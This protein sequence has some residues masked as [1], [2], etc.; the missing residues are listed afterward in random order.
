MA[1]ALIIYASQDK[2]Y[3]EA[4]IQ[5]ARIRQPEIEFNGLDNVGAFALDAS[6]IRRYDAVIALLSPEALA[7]PAISHVLAACAQNSDQE[8]VVVIIRPVDVPPYLA[9]TPRV[10]AE[11]LSPQQFAD[12]IFAPIDGVAT[13]EEIVA[14]EALKEAERLRGSGYFDDQTPIEDKPVG[15]YA[16]PPA[17]DTEAPAKE[18]PSSHWPTIEEERTLPTDV[19]PVLPPAPAQD[20]PA[21]PEPPA[22]QPSAPPYAPPPPAP[23]A[24]PSG[25]VGETVG[26]PIFTLPWD[27][28]G[29]KTQVT[30]TLQFSAYHPNEAPVEEWQT[31]L[32][33]TH[34]TEHLGQ[35]QADAGTFT[36]LGSAP[37]VAQGQALRKIPRNIEITVEPHMEGVTFSP[38][39]D[40]FIW[41]GEWHRSLFRYSGAKEL[42]GT[43]QKGWI[44]IYADHISPICT[45][46]VSFSFRSGIPTTALSVPHG[47]TVTS[48][49]FDTVFISYSHRDRE[50][51]RQARETYEKLGITAYHDDFLEAGDN[52]E[53]QLEGMIRT[54]RVFHLLWSDASAQSAE[55]RK[56]WAL[57]LEC[58][59]GEK[60]IRPWYWQ[61]QL[62]R[63]PEELRARKISFR[64][65]HLRRKLLRPSTW[66]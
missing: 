2:Q 48:N 40:S 20:Q 15:G 25:P 12:R 64:Y 26:S 32:V 22:A 34:L 28:R 61:R 31:L 47:V 50:P 21:A 30:E 14:F 4:F 44:D 49:V 58:Q 42:A 53:E 55:V 29:G 3:A 9:N 57:A 13:G 60:F 7:S 38:T 46:D 65:Q 59:K 36:E 52:Y 18:A 63:P 10:S 27:A 41:R 17:P 19:T 11:H 16:P 39:Q 37:T 51:M 8:L 66:L 23:G 5:A 1:Q 62:A 24:P 33:Y 43:V 56:E 54:A 35:V 45:I 6:A